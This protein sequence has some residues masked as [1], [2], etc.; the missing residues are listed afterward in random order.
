MKRPTVIAVAIGLLS[1]MLACTGES[2]RSRGKLPILVK[3]AF[4]HAD[5]VTLYSLNPT[6]LERSDDGF[7]HYHA[8]LGSTVVSDIGARKNLMD[9]LENAV[10]ENDG[11]KPACFEPRH[12]IRVK[13]GETSVDLVICFRCFQVQVHATGR[14][15]DDFAISDSPQPTFDKVLR[16]ANVPLAKKSPL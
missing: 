3:N 16:D 7:F 1:T 9:G 2:P 6:R 5:E 8:I 11:S 14:P 12:G 10:L 13:Q 4:E 15:M